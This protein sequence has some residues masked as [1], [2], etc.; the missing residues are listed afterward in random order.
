MKADPHTQARVIQVFSQLAE[1]MSNRDVDGGVALFADDPDVF[2]VGTGADEVRLGISAIREQIARDLGQADSVAWTFGPQ[3]ISAAGC[4][5]WT[6]GEVSIRVSMADQTH[7]V[8]VRLTTVLEQRGGRWLIQQ[9]HVSMPNAAQAVGQSWST[10]L[11]AV[12]DA[13][14]HERVDLRARTAPDGTVTLVFIDIEGSTQ[15]AEQ[16][17]DL[18]WLALLRESNAIV[19]AEIARYNGFEVKTIGDAFMLAFSSARRALLCAIAVQQQIS[20]YGMEHP[21]Q[22]VR[23]RIGL[24]AG[25]PVREGNDFHGLSVNFAS[26]IAGEAAGGEILASALL[27]QLT[28]S[29]GDIKFD[30]GRE[31]ALKGFGGTHHVYPVRFA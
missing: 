21:K 23:V 24:H 3:C 14:S 5:A 13:V 1:F 11:E 29:A 30:A 22:A 26:R 19:R 4:V 27:R 10:N 12:V 2:L 15:M 28:E 18:R 16:L 31:I 9:M 7:E 8:P 17:G 6:T 20:R 25:E